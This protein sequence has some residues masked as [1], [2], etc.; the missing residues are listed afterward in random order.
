[1][2]KLLYVMALL[3]IFINLY[4]TYYM[5]WNLKEKVNNVYK[6]ISNIREVL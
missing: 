1:M 4:T 3:T 2:V 5:V 6:R